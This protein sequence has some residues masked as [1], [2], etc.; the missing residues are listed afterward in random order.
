MIDVVLAI[1]ILTD[2]QRTNGDAA[3]GNDVDFPGSPPACMG[4][5]ML[6]QFRVELTSEL[7]R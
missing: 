5:G 7:E 4:G 6:D 2:T 3:V 1:A